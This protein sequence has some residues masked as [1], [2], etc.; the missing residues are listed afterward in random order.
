MIQPKNALGRVTS[1]ALLLGAVLL[2]VVSCEVPVPTASLDEAQAV[3]ETS[4]RTASQPIFT[5]YT[6]APDITNRSEVQRV[7]EREYPPLLRDAG[8]GGTVKVWFFIDKG[9]RVQD[10]QIQESSG[11]AQLD[12]AALAV[13]GV[14]KFTPAL[15][16]DETVPVWVAL[17]ILF[18]VR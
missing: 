12:Q 8:I 3:Q 15:N 10:T 6:V 5:P 4:V 1:A 16:R 11:H 14:V 13:A 2:L 7:L 18:Q 17:P 9:G